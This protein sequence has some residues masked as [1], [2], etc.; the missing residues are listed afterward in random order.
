MNVKNDLPSF[1]DKEYINKENAYDSDS[2]SDYIPDSQSESSDSF[3]SD[4]SDDEEHIVYK[5]GEKYFDPSYDDI[6][7]DDREAFLEYLKFKKIQKNIER[8]NSEIKK[9]TEDEALAIQYNSGYY[10]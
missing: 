9:Y 7:A 2:D 10:H 8:Y 4:S 5:N 1:N 6:M 3:I